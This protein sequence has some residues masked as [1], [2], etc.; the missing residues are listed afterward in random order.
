MTQYTNLTEVFSANCHQIVQ[1]SNN[2]LIFTQK[3]LEIVK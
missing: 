2:C 3:C 1:Y